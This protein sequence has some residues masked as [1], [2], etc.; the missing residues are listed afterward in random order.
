MVDQ[1]R[2]AGVTLRVSDEMVDAALEVYESQWRS[3]PGLPS[4]R[5]VVE[6]M[7]HRALE[8]RSIREP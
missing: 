2:Q 1:E 5:Y 8:A 6:E 4:N 3:P 7:L